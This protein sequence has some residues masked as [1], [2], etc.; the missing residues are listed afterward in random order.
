M[1][2]L[3]YIITQKLY[4]S[5]AI[6]SNT[7][8]QVREYSILDLLSNACVQYIIVACPLTMDKAKLL[9]GILPFE[10][11]FFFGPDR[12]ERAVFVNML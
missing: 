2:D 7:A 5:K 12:L 8:A 3:K 1:G 10:L 9:Q 6:N 11:R 4:A